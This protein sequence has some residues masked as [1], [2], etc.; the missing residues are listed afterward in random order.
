MTPSPSFSTMTPYDLVVWCVVF[1]S[2]MF[3]MSTAEYLQH[4]LSSSKYAANIRLLSGT[5]SMNRTISHHF[6][7]GSK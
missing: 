5:A 7:F 3:T 2:D 4:G 6:S 1:L